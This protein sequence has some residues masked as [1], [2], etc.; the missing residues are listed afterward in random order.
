MTIIPEGVG[1]TS[2]MIEAIEVVDVVG[3]IRPVDVNV[4]SALRIDTGWITPKPMHFQE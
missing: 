1:V 4:G 3:I 2:A